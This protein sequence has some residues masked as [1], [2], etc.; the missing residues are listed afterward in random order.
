MDK[1]RPKEIQD[2]L[3]LYQKT[4]LVKY[5]APDEYQYHHNQLTKGL[6]E[7]ILNEFSDEKIC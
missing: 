5:C 3:D 2:L 1:E 7:F 4:R 6:A